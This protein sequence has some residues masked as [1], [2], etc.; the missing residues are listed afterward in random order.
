MGRKGVARYR[1]NRGTLILPMRDSGPDGRFTAD[2]GPA[3]GRLQPICLAQTTDQSATVA[4][5]LRR[6]FW[7]AWV[8]IS[9]L[10]VVVWIIAGIHPDM[11]TGN[12]ELFMFWPGYWIFVLGPPLILFI[13]GRLLIWILDGLRDD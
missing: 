5:R 6:F 3:G 10:W 7:R 2:S 4:N 13:L 9:G 11:R 12:G 1:V 8:V